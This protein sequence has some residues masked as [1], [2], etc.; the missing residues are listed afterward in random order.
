MMTT[1]SHTQNRIAFLD[2]L[3]GFLAFWVYFGHL[4]MIT[5]GKDVIWGSPALAV[6]GFMVLS[7]FL[8][9]YHWILRQE[10]F[11]SFKTQTQDFYLRR[12]F[13]I[14]PLYYLLLAVALTYQ[15]KLVEIKTVVNTL[16]PPPWKGRFVV[17]D[18]P[19]FAS[20][21]LENILSHISFTFG[22]FPKFANSNILPD[23]SIGLEM[24]FYL[25]FP[26]LVFLIARI[27]PLSVT[28]FSLMATIATNKLFGL[29]LTNGP[30]GRFP[31]PSLIFFKL[32]LFL[33]GMAIAYAYLSKDNRQKLAWLIIGIVSIYGA[34]VQVMII[35]AVMA[36]LL[37]FDA[38]RRELLSK[39]GSWKIF[40]FLGDTSYGLYLLHLLI[41][42]PVLFYL[43][44]ESW[45]LSLSEYGKFGV[46]F[47]IITPVV[48]FLSYILHRVVELNGIRLARVISRRIVQN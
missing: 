30:L 7:G 26:L 29:Y 5:I 44:K 28:F 17:F 36:Y 22:F 4:L 37:I 39:I 42:Y 12:Y 19:I 18:N 45:F 21:S 43:F 9:A 31:Q 1:E 13:R 23:W 34:N 6:D 11:P 46:A 48:Y 32:N 35:T 38:E 41:I 2:M 40:R 33:A 14:A 15:S 20:L 47:V 3:R 24:Q 25:L 8:M 16:V 10:K 27:G